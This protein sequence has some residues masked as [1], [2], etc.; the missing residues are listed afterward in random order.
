MIKPALYKW[1]MLSEDRFCL[2]FVD[3][4]NRFCTRQEAIEAGANENNIRYKIE[5]GRRIRNN[6]RKNFPHLFR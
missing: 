5:E 4:T 1:W 3:G 2:V 6:N